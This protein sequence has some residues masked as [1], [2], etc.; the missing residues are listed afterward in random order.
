MKVTHIFWGLTYGGIETMLVNIVN[1]Q[2]ELGI[3]V[4]VVII[5]DMLE[6]E[7]LTKIDKRINVICIYRQLHSI[8]FGFINKINRELDKIDP[9]IIH[10]HGGDIFDFLNARRRKKSYVVV[11][12]HAMPTGRLGLP[13]RWGSM[14]QNFVLHQKGNVRALNRIKN[15]F[16]ISQSV[17]DALLNNYHIKSKV[18]YNGIKSTFFLPRNNR[19]P[20]GIFRIVQVSRLE[21]LTKG[22][23]ILIEAVYILKNKFGISVDVSFIGEGKSLFVLKNMADKLG[24]SDQIVFEGAKSQEFLADHLRDFDLFVQASRFEGFGLTVAEAMASNLPVLVSLGQGPSEVTQNDKYGWVFVNSDSEDLAIQ[25]Y[26]IIEHYDKALKKAFEARQYAFD[27]FDV[28]VTAS[29]YL[30]NYMQLLDTTF[31]K[32]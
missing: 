13:W 12:L 10:L 14:F 4:S 2:V 8:S 9:N 25:I 22:Q 6:T 11:T 21:H 26:N 30:N 31:D 23:D 3:E 19:K 20:Q 32:L 18:V 16:S 1:E 17:A 5:N 24:I 27:K 15:V 29:S 7:L 28:K